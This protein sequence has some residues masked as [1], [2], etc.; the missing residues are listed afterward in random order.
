MTPRD[1]EK[2]ARNKKI[3]N[4]T[5]ELKSLLPTVLAKT[6]F[7]SELSLNAKLGSKHDKYVDV[8]NKVFHSPLHFITTYLEGYKADL[9][10]RGDFAT[11]SNAYE[12]YL[13][14]KEIPEFKQYMMLFLER[15]FWRYYESLTR[16]KPQEKEAEIWIGQT[17][18]DYGIM[19]TPRY[20]NGQWENDKSEIRHFKKRYWSIG[21]I[22][23]TGL[24]I[25]DRSRK[26]TFHD[27][28]DYL[29]FFVDV[30]VRNSGSKYEREIAEMY[31]DYVGKQSNPE[32]V[33]LLIP[34]FRYEGRLKKHIHRLDFTI[35]NP[36]ELSKVGFELSPWSTH[37]ELT[38]TAGKTQK[39]INEQAKENFHKE[40]KKHKDYYRK[41]GIYAMIYTDK[42][43]ADTREVFAD[44][45]RYLAT[46]D[47]G[48]Q[49]S[50]HIFD[51]FFSDDTVF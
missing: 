21:H 16:T 23:E 7:D 33:P 2:T 12:T 41:H 51:D 27:V 30:L 45:V 15:T 11:K 29:E 17:N 4:L 19:I 10:G 20:K 13:L 26:K 6:G 36:I 38:G 24:L 34:E 39:Q 18:A 40:M 35:I 22:L 43:L 1:P 48:N 14:L 25:P 50:I 28:D 46:A 31:A 49:M 42:E 3:K 8:R 9:L 32:I 47:K 5:E 44:V 37:G